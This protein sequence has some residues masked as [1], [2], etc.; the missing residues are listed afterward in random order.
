MVG[1]AN[2]T[3][4]KFMNK[5]RIKLITFSLILVVVGGV[6]Y[7][8]FF[9]N[10][11]NN[12]SGIPKEKGGTNNF[13]ASYERPESVIPPFLPITQSTTCSFNRINNISY[14]FRDNENETGRKALEGEKAKIYY[15]SSVD[16]QPNI[17][18]FIDLDKKTPKMVANMGQDSLIKVYENEE[19]I[20]LIEESTLPNGSIIS[21]TIFKKDGIAI[22]SKQ[23]SLLG[24][25]YGLSA[26]GYCK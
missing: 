1:V 22:W 23:Y 24:I 7:L 9:K 8:A 14:E 26:M 4:N 18:S 13:I 21:Y 25:P 20:Q 17:I 10:T 2:K 16:S 19:T 5:E 11:N 6:I 3:I 15:D 12:N